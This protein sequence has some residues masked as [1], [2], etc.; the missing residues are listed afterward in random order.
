MLGNKVSH[1]SYYHIFVIIGQFYYC[2]SVLMHNYWIEVRQIHMQN[3]SVLAL[4]AVK[5][6]NQRLWNTPPAHIGKLTVALKLSNPVGR[7]YG[8]KQKRV[9]ASVTEG[10][11]WGSRCSYLGIRLVPLLGVVFPCCSLLCMAIQRSLLL[12]YCPLFKGWARVWGLGCLHVPCLHEAF[13]W[14]LSI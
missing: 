7:L 13:Q 9:E 4:F 1:D 2:S 8:E 5:D 14:V 11:G 10:D 6:I 12:A 3:I